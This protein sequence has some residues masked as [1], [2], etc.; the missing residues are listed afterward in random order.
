MGLLEPAEL[1][2]R[3]M[4]EKLTNCSAMLLFRLCI[5]VDSSVE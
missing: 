2:Y 1:K 5:S 4:G 3:R